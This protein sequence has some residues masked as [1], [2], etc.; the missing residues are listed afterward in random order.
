M[1]KS[2]DSAIIN[3]FFLDTHLASTMMTERSLSPDTSVGEIEKL[4]EARIRRGDYPI[5]ARLPTIRQ[6]AAQLGVNK[7]SAERAYQAL[8]RKGYLDLT[9]GRGA[10]VR[11]IDPPA[12]AA[13][14]RWL[15]KLDHVLEE[16]RANQLTREL[17]LKEIHASVD[18]IFGQARDH[19]RVAFIECNPADVQML[20]DQISDAVQHPLEG[21]LLSDFLN[22]PEEMARQFDL[23][24]TTF[25][26]LGE[27]SW[28]LD[29]QMRPK[30]V[31]VLAKPTHDTLLHIARLRA[32]TIG[33]VVT[34]AS[35]I[36]NLVH[37]IHT[38]HPTATILPVQV[39]DEPRM[40]MLLDKA[41]A[42]IVTRVTYERLL[43][44]QPRVPVIVVTFTVDQQ[45]L[46]FLSTRIGSAGADGNSK[47]AEPELVHV[48]A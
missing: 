17:V 16:A 47:P 6:L 10:F 13:D 32:A 38:Y 11:Q 12:A 21:V 4:L 40:K 43:H 15:L 14:T 3:P 34:L 7:Y 33:L 30:V 28:A 31:G 1:N 42:I 35:T 26:H 29:E 23:I 39:D 24:V 44:Y 5:G 18:R 2:A 41:D 27:V 36:D 25:F 22:Q 45:S 48:H 8:K 20:T 19:S 9:R 37:I 46:D